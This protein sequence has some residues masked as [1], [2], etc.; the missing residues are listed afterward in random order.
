MRYHGEETDT[1]EKM[2][3]KEDGSSAFKFLFG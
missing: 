2:K 3:E 1:A